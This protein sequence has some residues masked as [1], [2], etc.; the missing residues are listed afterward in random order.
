MGLDRPVASCTAR[1]SAGF[2]TFPGQM[3]SIS[4]PALWAQ[5]STALPVDSAP[6]SEVIDSGI[7][8]SAISRS[9]CSATFCPFRRGLINTPEECRADLSAMC[10]F[11]GLSALL[12]FAKVVAQ[13][14]ENV[15]ALSVGNLPFDFVQRKVDDVV[16]VY[17]SL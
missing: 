1:P 10:V 17:R 14:I 7:P 6:S 11:L 5:L 15:A 3:R 2:R 4:T 16:V 13:P 12:N 9:S 8:R